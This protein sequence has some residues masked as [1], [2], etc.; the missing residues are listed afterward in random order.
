MFDPFYPFDWLATQIVTRLFGLS[1]KSH[2][3]AS[4]HFF[5]YDVPKVLTLLIVISFIVETIRAEG[6]TFIYRLWS[7][8][9]DRR[10]L[11]DWMAQTGKMG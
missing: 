9:G 11:R 3:G 4:L 8:I 6:H 1:T 10:W 7:W 2:L 5:L